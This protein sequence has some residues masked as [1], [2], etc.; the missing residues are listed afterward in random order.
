[1]AALPAFHLPFLHLLLKLLSYFKF[2]SQRETSHYPNLSFLFKCW[3][4]RGRVT[5][6]TSPWWK[7]SVVIFLHTPEHDKTEMQEKRF[8]YFCSSQNLVFNLVTKHVFSFVM[9]IQAIN[10]KP[11]WM[12]DFILP[13]SDSLRLGGGQRGFHNQLSMSSWCAVDGEK[14]N[15]VFAKHMH[16]ET[17]SRSR[18]DIIAALGTSTLLLK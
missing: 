5:E 3:T 14:T 18:G 4:G 15:A 10:W 8:H 9:N 1:M 16:M 17:Q 13:V 12:G 7:D 6:L 2:D 11:N